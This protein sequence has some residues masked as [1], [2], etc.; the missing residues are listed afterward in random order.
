GLG[1]AG[2]REEEGYPTG[3]ADG[4]CDVH[5]R[6]ARPIKD[7]EI[8]MR[9]VRSDNLQINGPRLQVLELDDIAFFKKSVN[10]L[11][12]LPAFVNPFV[13]PEV[14]KPRPSG[15]KQMVEVQFPKDRLHFA[16]WVAGRIEGR[17]N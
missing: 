2:W 17:N 7:N 12:E 15:I 13:L 9:K 1:E 10:P 6:V 14:V 11:V 4:F 3:H 8:L 16:S 5:L